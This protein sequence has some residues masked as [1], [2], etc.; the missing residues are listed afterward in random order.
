MQPSTNSVAFIPCETSTPPILPCSMAGREGGVDPPERMSTLGGEG[1]SL[2]VVR[3]RL[4][5]RT[6]G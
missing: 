2:S 3:A 5:T 6:S 4:G 1:S